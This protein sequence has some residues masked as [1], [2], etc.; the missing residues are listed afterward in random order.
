MQSQCYVCLE[1]VTG[2]SA[3]TLKAKASFHMRD[4]HYFPV[5][6]SAGASGYL[7]MIELV[8]HCSSVMELIDEEKEYVL[9]ACDFPEFTERESDLQKNAEDRRAETGEQKGPFTK[10]VREEFQALKEALEIK[11]FHKFGCI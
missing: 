3:E 7:Y 1:I 4:S 2:T 10:R 6:T 11:L 8:R 5:L 9:Q